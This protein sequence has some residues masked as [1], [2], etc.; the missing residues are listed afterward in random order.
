ME[1]WSWQ[2]NRK[3]QNKSENKQPKEDHQTAYKEKENLEEEIKANK[4]PIGKFDAIEPFTTH[5]VELNPGDTCYIFSDGYADQFG[6]EK[7]KKFKTAN[8]KKLL[9]SMQNASMHEQK[10]N[11]FSRWQ[12]N[13]LHSK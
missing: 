5:E 6:G 8:F 4:Q 13:N 2:H 1:K 12:N 10:A 11:I 3:K 9:L 7:G